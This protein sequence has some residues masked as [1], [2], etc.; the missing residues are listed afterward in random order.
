[1]RIRKKVRGKSGK[2]SRGQML[3]EAMRRAPKPLMTTDE[4][5]ALT[6]GE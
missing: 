3:L 5:M 2:K 1:V 4:I 6:R